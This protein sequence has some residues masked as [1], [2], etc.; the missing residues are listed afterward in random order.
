MPDEQEQMA[1]PEPGDAVTLQVEG[2]VSRIEGE[3]AYVTP[4]MVNGLEVKEE[5]PKAEGRNPNGEET[6]A[7]DGYSALEEQAKGQTL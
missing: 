2:K 1:A 4:T 6:P 7:D 5:N 3:M